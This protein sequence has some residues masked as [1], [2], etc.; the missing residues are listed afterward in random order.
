V[1]YLLA[2]NVPIR[3]LIYNL[4]MMAE[5]PKC[6]VHQ[7]DMRLTAR[8]LPKE[9]VYFLCPKWGCIQRYRERDGH[10]TT[11]KLLDS[12]AKGPS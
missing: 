5:A 8:E 10:F 6:P 1:G 11:A 12:T 7:V 9:Q 4:R 2:S 3:Q